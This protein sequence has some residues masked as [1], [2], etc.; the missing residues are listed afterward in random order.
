MR[1]MSGRDL[2][3]ELTEGIA[4]LDRVTQRMETVRQAVAVL[5]A[6]MPECVRHVDILR[7]DAFEGVGGQQSFSVAL[8]NAN[9]DGIV[10]TSVYNRMD[11]RVYAKSIQGG[12]S[13]HALTEEEQS[14][15]KQAIAR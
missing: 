8:L 1:V 12:R 10:L 9:G 15:V 14:V 5:Q 6:Q 3:K 4:N 7:Y 11:A 13:S 2:E